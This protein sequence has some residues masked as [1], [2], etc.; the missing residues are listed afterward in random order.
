MTR[1]RLTGWAAPLT[2]LAVAL[3]LWDRLTVW[4]AIPPYVLPPPGLVWQTLIA[5]WPLLS[6]AL[7]I[8]ARTALAALGLAILGGA[9]LAI[10]F[11]Q[12]RTVERAFYPFAVILQVTPVVAIAPLIFIYVDSKTAAMLIVAWI[13]AFFPV[14]A[15]TTLGLNSVD[16]NLRDLF[17]LYGA[18]RLERLRRLQLPAALPNLL[19]GV[20]IAGGLSLVGAVVAEFV[21]GAGGAGDG[22][23][24][25]FLEAGY[26]LNIDRMFAALALI[27]GLGVAIYAVLAGISRLVLRHWHASAL[28]G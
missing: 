4:A 23:A 13:V 21:A 5:D 28:P 17:R 1:D 8:T 26:R 7:W 3:I 10:L 27:A 2:A 24:A 11:H 18:T 12:S 19:G 25:V 22:L 20:R 14:M 15:G 16:P 6:G 9:G